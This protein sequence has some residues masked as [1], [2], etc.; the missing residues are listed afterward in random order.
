MQTSVRIY[1]HVVRL[2]LRYMLFG[3]GGDGRKKGAHIAQ[4]C[5]PIDDGVFALQS[6]GGGGGGS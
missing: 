6:G 5:D 2:K 4:R 3:L 1:F